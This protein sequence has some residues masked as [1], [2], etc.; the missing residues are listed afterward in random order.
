[1]VTLE[2]VVKD[3]G[4][5]IAPEKLAAIFDAFVQ[6]DSSTTRRFGGT[7]LGLSISR[8]L[9]ELMGGRIWVNSAVGSGSTFHFQVRLQIFKGQLPHTRR[10]DLSVLRGAR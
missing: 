2:F 8:R 10:A 5:G 4:I 9:I 3:T 7:G 1:L 6:A